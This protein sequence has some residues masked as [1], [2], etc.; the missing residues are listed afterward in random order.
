MFLFLISY[1]EVGWV[2]RGSI[3]CF[4]SL[5]SISSA[6]DGMACP[7][8]ESKA[9]LNIRNVSGMSHETL[10][11]LP[12]GWQIPNISGLGLLVLS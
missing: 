12:T 7:V 10:I 11:L 3:N 2:R 1:S 9:N 4:F 5:S 6:Y 8:A